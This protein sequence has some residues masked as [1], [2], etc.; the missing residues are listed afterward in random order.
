M[1]GKDAS[2]REL[3]PLRRLR[4]QMPLQPGYPPAAAGQ[5]RGLLEG[6]GGEPLIPDLFG[7][8]IDY[9]IKNKQRK[10]DLLIDFS[11]CIMRKSS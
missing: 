3:P 6:A 9:I 7:I 11:G 10:F 8:I 1:A 4:R 5:L 2:D